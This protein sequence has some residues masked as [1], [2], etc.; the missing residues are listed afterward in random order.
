MHQPTMGNSPAV[1]GPT[2]GTR[3]QIEVL[4]G[5]PDV[6]IDR[7]SAL[8][9]WNILPACRLRAQRAD[10]WVYGCRHRLALRDRDVSVAEAGSRG[11]RR[12][13]LNSPCS[14]NWTPYRR[15]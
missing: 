11:S 2:S 3:I 9:D 14:P 1:S 15:G 13:V 4:D 10:I 6:L 8:G 12:A 5:C 7:A